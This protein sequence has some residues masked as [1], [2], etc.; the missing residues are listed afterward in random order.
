MNVEAY[1]IGSGG[2][3]SLTGA[4]VYSLQMWKNAKSKEAQLGLDWIIANQKKEWKQIDVYEWYYHTQAC[5]QATGVSGA[6]R[7]WRS[8][9]RDFPRIVCDAQSPEGHWSPG[10]HFHGDTEIFRTTL[11]ILMLE[12]YYRY[13]FP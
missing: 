10:A 5:F 13:V 11:A 2:K 8:W 4:G 12:V 9:N 6:S 3:P 7:Y 1:K